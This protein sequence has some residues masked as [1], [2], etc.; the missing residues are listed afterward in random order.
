M[1]IPGYISVLL[2]PRQAGNFTQ[3]LLKPRTLRSLYG[4]PDGERGGWSTKDK[5][6]QGVAAF[7]DFYLAVSFVFHLFF[8]RSNEPN[9]LAGRG[10]SSIHTYTRYSIWP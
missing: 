1:S 9:G 4:V 3:V 10:M 8:S 6:R 5:N 7:N 2:C